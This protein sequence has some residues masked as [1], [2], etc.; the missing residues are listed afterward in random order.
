M[1][2]V[3]CVVLIIMAVL[4]WQ[5]YSS[6]SVESFGDSRLYLSGPTKCFSCE[7][8]MIR[9]MGPEYAFLGKQTKCFDCEK[10]LARAHP[11]LANYTHGTRCFDCEKQLA[12]N[13]ASPLLADYVHAQT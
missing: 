4:L 2:S 11:D 12:A 1:C 5:Q 8:D 10:Q 6:S 3:A 9:R 13:N 7:R